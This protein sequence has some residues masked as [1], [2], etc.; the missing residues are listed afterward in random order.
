MF[1]LFKKKKK[2]MFGENIEA[3]CDYCQLNSG[4]EDIICPNYRGGVCRKYLYDPLKRMPKTPKLKEFNK[5][6]F[7]L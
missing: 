6:D 2:K 4:K 3:S 5:E 1:R 7:T